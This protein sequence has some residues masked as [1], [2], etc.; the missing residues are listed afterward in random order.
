MLVIFVARYAYFLARGNQQLNHGASE[1]LDIFL[2]ANSFPLHVGVTT[3]IRH[4]PAGRRR[5]QSQY[6]IDRPGP[7]Y[8]IDLSYFNR[9]N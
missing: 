6:G 5:V 4:L 7:R 3:V 1:L 2:F 8:V 9:L